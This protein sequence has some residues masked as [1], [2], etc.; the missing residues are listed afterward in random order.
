MAS[1]MTETRISEDLLSELGYED[2]QTV[3]TVGLKMIAPRNAYP[4]ALCRYTTERAAWIGRESYLKRYPQYF[5][6]D[7]FPE[8]QSI[9]TAIQ[10][11]RE[12]GYTM[13]RIRDESGQVVREIP[14]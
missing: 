5:A 3:W 2:I 7:G 1:E 9:G 10:R 12:F 4:D 8:E 11:A 6:P 14:V 13:L